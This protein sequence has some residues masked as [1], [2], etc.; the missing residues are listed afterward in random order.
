MAAVT[1]YSG[2]GTLELGEE[3][4][5]FSLSASRGTESADPL[6]LDFFLASKQWDPVYGNFSWQP[7]KPIYGN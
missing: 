3:W 7:S 6:T 1:T 4:N 5:R 2:F